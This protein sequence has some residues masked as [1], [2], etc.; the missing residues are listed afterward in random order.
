MKTFA[1]ASIV[2]ENDL[3]ESKKLPFKHHS[4]ED[5]NLLE[6]YASELQKDVALISTFREFTELTG[7]DL[8]DEQ[9]VP[10]KL[11]Q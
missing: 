2:Y 4:V 6:E 8:D 7:G 10:E 3:G 9:L 11:L 5:I 1:L